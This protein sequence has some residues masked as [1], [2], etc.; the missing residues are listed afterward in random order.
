MPVNKKM[1]NAMKKEYGD[2]KGESIYYAME[3]EM[4]HKHMMGKKKKSKKN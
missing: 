1:M 4:G 2:R 3:N